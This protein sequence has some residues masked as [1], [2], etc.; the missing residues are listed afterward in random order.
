MGQAADSKWTTLVGVARSEL[1][2]RLGAAPFD[3]R[4]LDVG[5]LSAKDVSS[6]IVNN[7]AMTPKT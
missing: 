1:R 4:F 3:G 6:A 5:V 7:S 2:Q